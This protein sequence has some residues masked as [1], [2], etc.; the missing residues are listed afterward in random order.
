MAEGILLALQLVIGTGVAL[1]FPML[2]YYGI[3]TVRQSPKSS[4]YL[5]VH[6]P[7]GTDA[8]DLERQSLDD[9]KQQERAAWQKAQA[10]YA[11]T[12]FIVMTPC[13]VAAIFGG[14]L[15]GVSA[16]GTGLLTGGILCAV[17]GY[18][19]YWNALEPWMRFAS[20]LASLLMLLFIGVKYLGV[21]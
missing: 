4:D 13:G 20:I 8:S 11:K 6:A 14:Y 3:A 16:I 18:A 15:L 12:L 21:Q 10:G 5:G 17:Y 1:L 7:L 9:R 2:I 19:R